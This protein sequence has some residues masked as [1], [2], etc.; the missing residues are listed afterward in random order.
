MSV[1][2]IKKYKSIHKWLGALLLLPLLGWTITGAIFLFKPGYGDAY[3]PLNV[4]S[5]AIAQQPE[6]TLHPAWF[7]YRV[8]RTALGKHLLIRSQ[9]GWQQLHPKTQ[10]PRPTPKHADIIRLL[11]DAIVINPERYGQTVSF[12]GQRYRT[13]TQVELHLDWSTLNLSQHG[14]DRAVI[15]ALYDIHYLRWSGHK[16]IDSVWGI[17]GLG[18]LLI[19][20]LLGAKLL[21]SKAPPE[22][23]TQY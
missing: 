18:A 12:D 2:K 9:G 3:T 4:R 22:D 23:D 17:I 11:E 20:T 7:E 8:L 10:Q 13:N 19:L 5:Y 15:D 21:L 6:I 14:P 16:L 1:L